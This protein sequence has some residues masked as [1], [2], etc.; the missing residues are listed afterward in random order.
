LAAIN[1]KVNFIYTKDS[2]GNAPKGLTFYRHFETL[3]V[4]YE[5]S[6]DVE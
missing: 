3:F 2:C 6:D 1:E 4:P 5:G